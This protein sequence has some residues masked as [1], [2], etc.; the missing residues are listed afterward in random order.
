VKRKKLLKRFLFF[1]SKK[2]VLPLGAFLILFAVLSY[3]ASTTPDNYS[4][5]EIG[6]IFSHDSLKELFEQGIYFPINLFSWV[7]LKLFE[8]SIAFRLL[9]SAVLS[10]TIMALFYAIKRWHSL[11]IALLT[12]GLFVCN[13]V[14]RSI[15]RS[16]TDLS[17]MFVW[18]IF[19]AFILW[20]RYTKSTRL[21]PLFVSIASLI[22]L[23]IPGAVW[24]VLVLGFIYRKRV[25]EILSGIKKK[26]LA[27]GIGV[28]LI[29]LSPLILT[30]IKDITVLRQLLLIPEQLV[31]SDMPTNTLRLPSAFI[32]KMPD[33]PALTVGRLPILDA[34]SA[35]FAILGVYNYRSYLKWDRT[36]M[37]L[38]V[39]AV[40]LLLA[41]FGALT[42]MI[43]LTIPFVFMLIS[44]GI[45]YVLEIW[46][47][48]F[49]RNPFARLFGSLTITTLVLIGCYYHV[50]RFYV[51]WPQ[52]PAT[53]AT[54]NQQL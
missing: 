46:Y 27:I 28:A 48:V 22:M 12:V 36:G 17:F 4:T 52:V 24:F 19:I 33:N 51:V 31:V 30:I 35:A 1:V 53:R 37:L 23:Y 26:Y 32:Y 44:S 29:S 9:G 5:T 6:Y 40:S 38:I 42:K 43:V 14:V 13:S 15:S 47:G 21:L 50:T 18:M 45:S 39:G 7:C 41:S 34:V 25:R 49:P 8:H 10:V 11:R 3:G 54:F 20:A 16:A 2:G